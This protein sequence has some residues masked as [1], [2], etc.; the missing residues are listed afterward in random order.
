MDS[1]IL[2]ATATDVVGAMI[3]GLVFGLLFSAAGYV[4][5]AIAGAVLLF[6]A[7]AGRAYDAVVH[8]VFLGY[9][10]SMIMAHA[11]TILPAVLGIL[12][13]YR[14][15]FWVPAALLQI[16]LVVRLLPGDDLGLVWAKQLG[17]ALGV[18]ALLLFLLTAVT[19]AV[20]AAVSRR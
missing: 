15:A 20:L 8:A 10:F 2:A 14:A 1:E 4:W 7:P 3:P 6:G 18:A 5:L 9:T 11:T 16:G 13:P 19:S 12:L 17:G